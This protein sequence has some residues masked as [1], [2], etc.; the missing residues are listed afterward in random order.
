VAFADD[1]VLIATARTPEKAVCILESTFE[2]FCLGISRTKSAVLCI[3]GPRRGIGSLV[4]G[5]PVVD[6]YKYLGI[7]ICRNFSAAKFLKRLE[8]DVRS[9]AF[10]IA[11]L[12]AG[13]GSQWFSGHCT[14]AHACT[15]LGVHGQKINPKQ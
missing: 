7:D 8:H 4:R 6:H 9:K 5:I 3:Q 15:T 13:S 1:L 14:L 2:A 12:K 11:R 10:R